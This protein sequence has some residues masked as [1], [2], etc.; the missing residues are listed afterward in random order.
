MSG[1]ASS[2][3]RKVFY[4]HPVVLLAKRKFPMTPNLDELYA[5]LRE[6]AVAGKPQTYGEL[7]GAYRART[8]HRF[9]PRGWGA[10]LGELNK[11]LDAVGAPA[12]SALVIRQDT[13]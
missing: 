5:V 10:P 4:S 8:G 11:R 1:R 12:L 9:G 2:K 3:S 13:K 6:W 7:S